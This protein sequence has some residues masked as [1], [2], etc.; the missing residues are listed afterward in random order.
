ML[1]TPK[2]LRAGLLGVTLI[3]MF[4]TTPI[5]AAQE[6]GPISAATAKKEGAR[7]ITHARCMKV[8]TDRGNIQPPSAC[9]NWC[10][11]G[12]CYRSRSEPYCVR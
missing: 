6:T 3:A 8:C 11:A 5:A 12:R 4:A 1:D 7:A 10:R 9:A 2:L